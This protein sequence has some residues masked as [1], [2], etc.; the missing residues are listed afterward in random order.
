MEGSS[1]QQLVHNFGHLSLELFWFPLAVWTIIAI[2]TLII[3]CS[4]KAL[5]PLYKYHLRVAIIFAIPFGFIAKY[6]LYLYQK[7]SLSN[8]L[9]DPNLF[10]FINPI[11]V[12]FS[13]NASVI[14]TSPDFFNPNFIIDISTLFIFVT[15]IVLLIRFLSNIRFFIRLNNNLEKQSLNHVTNLKIT[16]FKDIQVAFVDQNIVPFTYGWNKPVI[17]L[18]NT[19]RDIHEKLHMAIQHELVHIK[20]AD[21][22]LQIILSLIKSVFWFH[23]IIWFQN[24]EIEIYREISCDQEVLNTSNISIKNYASM[25]LEL[26]PV[27]QLYNDFSLNMAAQQS[28]LKKRISTMKYHHLYKS[29][30]KKSILFF[31]LITIGIIVPISCTDLN[32]PSNLTEEIIANTDFIINDP[33]LYLNGIQI[34]AL[35]SV[36]QGLTLGFGFSISTEDYGSFVYSGTKFE[37][38]SKIGFLQDNTI[39]YWDNE[40]EIK[41]VNK[42]NFTNGISGN[43]WVKHFPD[44]KYS[45]TLLQFANSR[46]VRDGSFIN[47]L[48]E[49]VITS[50]HTNTETLL[51]ADQMPKIIGGL[52]SIHSKVVYPEKARQEGI[53]GRVTVQFIVNEFGEVENPKVIKGIGGGCDENALEAVKLAKFEPGLHNGDPVKVQYSLPIVFRLND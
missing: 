38:A 39:T 34:L 8:A 48:K 42:I 51:V 46:R 41:L 23:P 19:I 47:D 32:S 26:I 29:S 50:S 28:T 7:N 6:G 31:L 22:I 44:L 25:L 30:L 16:T 9:L 53:E 11:D 10:V 27:N 18:P 4:F 24:K 45:G 40:M 13:S 12:V 49:A 3:L 52:A 43:I 15:S 20:R 36:Q 14:N 37:G 17:V 21:Y 2:I 35:G 5:D 1:I 33:D